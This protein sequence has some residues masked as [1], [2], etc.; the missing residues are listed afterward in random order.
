MSTADQ[1]RNQPRIANLDLSNLKS[2]DIWT[3]QDVGNLADIFR[4]PGQLRRSSLVKLRNLLVSLEKFERKIKGF[5]DLEKIAFYEVQ[6]FT[7]EML[8]A[9]EAESNR[10]GEDKVIHFYFTLLRESWGYGNPVFKTMW[11]LGGGVA[12][13][14]MDIMSFAQRWLLNNSTEKRVITPEQRASVSFKLN[15]YQEEE[16]YRH[17]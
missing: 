16:R 15:E 1:C 13:G 11:R 5:T 8:K 3:Y 17:Y 12:E 9:I 10:V 7:K 4:Q 6:R 2:L 14:A